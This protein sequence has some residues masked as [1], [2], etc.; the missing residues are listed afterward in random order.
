MELSEL[1]ERLSPRQSEPAR[2]PG[3]VRAAVLI[4]LLEVD[5]EVH[6]LFEQR[7][8]HIMQ[9]GEICFPGGHVEPG[10]T[11]AEAA[12][13]ETREE[14]LLERDQV[15][16]IAPLHILSGHGSREIWS[17]LGQLKGYRGGM[18]PTEVARVFTVPLDFFLTVPPQTCDGRVVVE[19]GADFPY[20]LIPGGRDYPWAA[21][22]RRFY[23]YHTPGGVV[24]GLTAELLHHFTEEIG[25]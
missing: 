12:L 17:F 15:E 18:D 16:L 9:G 21:A 20:E 19:P 22:P 10:E 2:E 23:F 14:L 8:A 11:P 5:G 1:R 7:E 4:P 6:V 3:T 25:K 24:W 13:R